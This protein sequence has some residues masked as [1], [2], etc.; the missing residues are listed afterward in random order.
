MAQEGKTTQ[1][2]PSGVQIFNNNAEGVQMK[3]PPSPN[4]VYLAWATPLPNILKP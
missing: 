3:S 4:R 2:L 1:F